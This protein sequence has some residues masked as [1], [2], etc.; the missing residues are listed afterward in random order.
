[1]QLL[2]EVPGQSMAFFD[3]G[4]I[5]LYLGKAESEDFRSSPLIYYNVEDIHRAHRALLDKG[6]VFEGEPHVVH[7]TGTH[8]LWLAAFR[9]SEGHHVHL[10]SE[11][12][13]A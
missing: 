13:I 1:M 3:C 2:F 10:M 6:V 11:A 4:G 7:R 5:R 12:A 8:E 9:D